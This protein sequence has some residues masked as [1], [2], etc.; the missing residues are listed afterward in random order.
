VKILKQGVCLALLGAGLAASP[1]SLASA[2]A[3]TASAASPAAADQGLVQDIRSTAR[4]TVSLSDQRATGK[5]GFASVAPGGDLLPGVAGDTKAAA[6]A[7]ADQYLSRFGGAFGAGAGELGRDKIEG[8]AAGGF[9]ATYTQTYQGLPVFGSML[10]ANVDS[11]GA[12][13]SVNGFVAPGIDLATDARLSQAEAAQ[14]AIALVKTSPSMARNGG[15]ARAS[16]LRAKSNQLM[17]YRTGVVKG[18][19]G[20]NQ[21]AYVSEV[22]DEKAVREQVILDAN[23]G[24]VLN[25]YSM[26]DNDLN[27]ELHEISPNSTPIWKEGDPFPGALNV[28]QQNL[29]KTSGESYWFFRN[30]FARD[31]YDGFGA[32][33]I[34]V[35]NDPS[36][37][38]PN[39]NWNGITTNYCTGVT[40][41]DV[42][43]HEWGHAYTEYTDGL[44]YQWQS[45]ALNEAYSDI[46]GETLDL[47][48][49]REDE[50]EG[51]TSTKRPVGLCSL[52]TRSG[53]ELFVNTPAS[54]GHC[55]AS[56]A[57]WGPTIT[58]AGFTDDVVVATDTGASTTD[59]CDA[60]FANAAAVN[61]NFVYVDRGNCPFQTKLNNAIANGA[62]GII[63]GNNDATAP[64][65]MSG[66]GTIPGLM[67]SQAKGTEIKAA[68]PPVNAT[69][70]A[71]DTSPKADSYRWLQGEKS[72]AFGGAI[73]DMWNPNCYGDP[74]KVSDVQYSCSTADAGGVHTNSGVV[75]HGYS[76]LVDGGTFNG[77]TVRGIGLTK[78]AHIYWVA[79]NDYMTPV[80][81]FVDHADALQHSCADLIGKQ[82]TA[83]STATNDYNVSTQKITADDCAQIPLMAAAVELRR[84]PVQCDF[85]PL[86]DPATPA[87]GLCGAGTVVKAGGYKEDF[88]DGL[89][90]W[91]TAGGGPVY[92]GGLDAPWVSSTELPQG[93]LPAGDTTAA[94]GPAPDRGNCNGAAG[95]FSSVNYLTS[96]DITVGAAGDLAGSAKLSFD[97]NVETE[98]GYDGGVVQIS[99]NGGAFT[100]VPKTAYTFNKPTTL[101][102]TAGGNTNPLQGQDG[103][104]GTDGGKIESDWGTS[105]IDLNAAGVAL[106]DTIK[107]RFAIGRDGCGG[108]FGWWVDNIKVTTCV[109]AVTATV[110]ATHTPEPSTFGSASSVN[111]TVSGGS[112]TPTGTVT[113]KEGATTLGTGTLDATGKATVA[114]PATLPVGS[115]SL[116][117]SYS[118]GGPYGAATGSVTAT[119]KAAVAAT[120]TT[121]KA[122]AKVK[123]KKPFDVTATVASAGGTPTGTVQVYDGTKLIGT[124]TLS[125]GT[126]KIHI[127]KKLKKGK[128]T[129][130]VKYLGTAA[131]SASQTTVTVKITQKKR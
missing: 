39:A 26:I 11:S 37:S 34:T 29:V 9:T 14:R 42:V 71:T 82:I 22:T 120:T 48:N 65:S 77:S 51:D 79:Q 115:H 102:N 121:A 93:N 18:E 16:D 95:D 55:D 67:V 12:L 111:V 94:F 101:A 21:L 15:T 86:L 80:S 85:H 73:R 108:V 49:N 17:V 99:K 116:T 46:W 31:S 57:A 33:R 87:T 84:D 6:A 19:A 89:A 60:V 3:P 45:G 105:I 62:T 70:R 68:A 36:I 123:A 113:V 76:L 131:F 100:T 1:L 35:N 112:G 56:P 96:P 90:G 63:V 78:A 32:K 30:A 64:F 110:A 23:S 66:T 44:I 8:N 53:V 126:V 109:T 43:A 25:R 69:M 27:R 74:G 125:G 130:T 92:A 97:H 122:P 10:R 41:D 81:G 47:V 98:L 91:S 54:I 20:T 119:V 103:F 58:A 104:T 59:G 72:T 40:S 2:T 127:T 117:V 61:G 128:H 38:C 24:K 52:Y 7:K 88:E 118:G 107:V 75:N 83:L 28:E 50:G 13:R 124:G 106:G 4:G 114:L 129:L 5:V